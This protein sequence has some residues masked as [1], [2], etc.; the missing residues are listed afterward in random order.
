MSLLRREGVLLLTAVQFLTRLPTPRSLPFTPDAPVRASRWFPL[1]GHLVG[2]ICAA[3]WLAAGHVWSPP[4]A[5][6][7]AVGAGVL[8]TGAFHED[9]LADTADG[10]GGGGDPGHR[11]LI[12]K[13]S[14]LG[15]YGAVALLLVVGL[16][17]AALA[18]LSPARGALALVVAHGAARAA[19]VLVMRFTP[20]V[21]DTAGAKGRPAGA[22]PTG[23]ETLFAA[24]LGFVPMLLLPRAAV[25]GALLL[26]GT[27][28]AMLT[29][30]ARRLVGGHTG[31]VLGAVEQVAETALLLAASGRI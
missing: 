19:A 15:T 26:T 25:L 4:V 23:G 31:D 10:L 5:A 11:L 7:L 30:A 9:G 28:V 2:A 27:A 6:I 14:R 12:M 24:V 1:V 20:Y 29:R 16:R 17:I 21:G 13:D 18:S 8:V 22:R 3:A